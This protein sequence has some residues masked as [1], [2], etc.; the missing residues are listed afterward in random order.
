MNKQ[1]WIKS[2]SEALNITNPNDLWSYLFTTQVEI[3]N[4]A[5]RADVPKPL[6]IL[7]ATKNIAD[8]DARLLM[9]EGAY[10]SLLIN[11]GKGDM[12]SVAFDIKRLLTTPEITKPTVDILNAILTAPPQTEPDP[13][14][15]PTKLAPMYV[16]AGY[17]SLAL[18]EVI[19]AIDNPQ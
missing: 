5:P 14:W 9:N 7:E 10:Q 11:Y 16:A 3:E 17:P 15:Q 1:Q 2:Q 12:A 8:N 18:N 4:T 19:E 6:S 13:N